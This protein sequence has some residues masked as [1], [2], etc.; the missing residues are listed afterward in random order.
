MMTIKEARKILKDIEVTEEQV[1]KSA[2]YLSDKTEKWMSSK[3]YSRQ[4]GVPF[5]FSDGSIAWV[6]IWKMSGIAYLYLTERGENI[7]IGSDVNECAKMLYKLGVA[8][9][10]NDKFL[11][12]AR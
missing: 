11:D 2:K 5:K 10:Q 3:A 7:Y 8:H 9:R 12:C 4:G 6:S 1:K